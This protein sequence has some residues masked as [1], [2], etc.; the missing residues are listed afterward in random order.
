LK[1]YL[2]GYLNRIRLSRM[3]EREASRNLELIWL[4]K[5]LRPGYRT[6]AK[7]RRDN[8]AALKAVNRQLC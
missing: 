3:L 2:Y 4:M 8:W 7:F 5:G 6:I 1:L